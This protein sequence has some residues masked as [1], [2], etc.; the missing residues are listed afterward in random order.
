[1]SATG[2]ASR[3]GIV[4]YG[5]GEAFQN[6]TEID[7]V[8]FDKT[9]TLTTGSFKVVDHLLFLPPL[10]VEEAAGLTNESFWR[11]LE[12]V[13]ETSLHPIAAGIR[14]FARLELVRLPSISS[15]RIESS[16]EIAGRG[17]KAVVECS[18]VQVEILVGNELFM[19][20]NFAIYRSTADEER[21]RTELVRWAEQGKSVVL[22][23]IRLDQS[24][25][26]EIV[27]LFS[28]QDLP[29]PEAAYIVRSLQ[30]TGIAVFICS[31][32]NIRT[33]RAVGKEIGLREEEV[34]AGVLPDGKREVVERLQRGAAKGVLGRM[35]RERGG[36][37]RFWSRNEDERRT[38]VMFVGDGVRRLTR[39]DEDEADDALR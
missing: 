12:V 7:C 8:V 2:I 38:R 10:A 3:N 22:V 32:D 6:A 4:P 30:Q 29:R 26:F 34:F 20:D 5:G 17:T 31:G 15:I 36:W 13:E 33:A 25:Q 19:E 37:R 27:A 14:S 11:V 21:G 39:C 9:G 16:E 24:A 28:V 1:M 35:R 18:A 23:A